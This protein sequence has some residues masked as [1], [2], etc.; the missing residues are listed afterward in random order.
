MVLFIIRTL[1]QHQQLYAYPTTSTIPTTSSVT[2]SEWLDELLVL[3]KVE[4][5]RDDEVAFGWWRSIS[6]WRNGAE[7]SRGQWYDIIIVDVG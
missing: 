5:K 4:M 1:L 3:E 2:S 6:W 7:R